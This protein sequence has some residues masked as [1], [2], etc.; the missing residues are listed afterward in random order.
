MTHY[1]LTTGDSV[2][3][4]DD[5]ALIPADPNN[6]DWV[7]YLAWKAAGNTP[8]PAT[9]KSPPTILQAAA[10]FARFTPAEQAAIQAA[11]AASP[12]IGVGLTLGLAQGYVNLLSPILAGWMAALVAAGAIT[13]ARSAVIMTP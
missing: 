3:R 1:A 11:A 9:L 12:Q 10:F 8:N 6:P 7:A 5:Q 2:L 4:L 13:S